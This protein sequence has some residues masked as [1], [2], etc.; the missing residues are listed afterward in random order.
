[1]LEVLLHIQEFS[2]A[3]ETRLC[4]STIVLSDGI[5]VLSSSLCKYY[6]ALDIFQENY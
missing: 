2:S 1:M 3:L 5:S 4:N 6:V